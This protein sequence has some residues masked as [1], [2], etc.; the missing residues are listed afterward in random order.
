M[1]DDALLTADKVDRDRWLAIELRHLAALA[2]VARHASFSGAADSLGYVQSAV[3]QQISSLERIVGCSLVDRSARP[4]SVTVTDAGRTLLDHIDEILEQLRLAKEDVDALNHKLERTVSFG[5]DGSFGSRLPATIFAALLQATGGDGWD[6]VERGSSA[7][8]LRRVETGQLDAAFV[9]LPIASGPFFALEL[10]RQPYMLVVPAVAAA[11]GRGVEE[12]LEQWPLV[13]IDDCP[14]SRALLERRDRAA[15][16]ARSEHS[17]TGPASALSI[18]RAGAAAAVMTTMDVP[19]HDGSVATIPLPGL[20]DRVVGLAWH[21]E[22]DECPAVVGLRTAARRV[23]HE[24]PDPPASRGDRP[25]PL[26]IR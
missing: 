15:R 23:F 3:S 25:A 4:R 16:P 11:R 24:S 18:V 21:R 6:R 14:A 8:L 26:Q 5:V 10:A 7:R 20:P 19:S 17:A 13:Q 1:S 2:T 12:I 9:P 22:R